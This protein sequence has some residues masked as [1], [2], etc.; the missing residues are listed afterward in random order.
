MSQKM[1]TAARLV[2]REILATAQVAPT[3]WDRAT[4]QCSAD[5]GVEWFAASHYR[6]ERAVDGAPAHKDTGFVTVLYFEQPGLEAW[7]DG[8][9]VDV[10]PVA[11]HFIVNFGGALELLT[12]R[13]AVKVHAVLH[14]VRQC[15]RD[16]K[17]AEDRFSFAAFLNPSPDS[18]AFQLTAD[19][20]QLTSCGSVED[21]LREFN[22]ATWSDRH[23]DFGTTRGPRPGGAL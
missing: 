15:R 9:W 2:L 13:L 10:L 23:V 18:Q 16:D 14:R 8:E 7:N 19:G 12:K 3:H 20:H 17:V 1:C 22:R 6:A 4:D 5:G 21:F 11:G